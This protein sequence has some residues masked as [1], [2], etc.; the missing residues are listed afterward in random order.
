M[1]AFVS[2]IAGTLSPLDFFDPT[3]IQQMMTRPRNHSTHAIPADQ[4]GV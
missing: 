2:V 4:P 3:H 1:D